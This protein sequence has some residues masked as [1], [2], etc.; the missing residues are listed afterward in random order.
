MN[1]NV[2]FMSSKLLITITF[3]RIRLVKN[4]RGD[5]ELIRNFKHTQALLWDR[6]IPQNV[7][8]KLQ[9]LYQQ[10][11]STKHQLNYAISR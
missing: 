2:N 1:K 11:S 3:G 7:S 8:R 10:W 4:P 5:I 6:M 9:K